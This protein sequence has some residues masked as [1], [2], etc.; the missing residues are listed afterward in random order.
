MA[1]QMVIDFLEKLN[2]SKETELES[3][4]IK[5]ESLM[6]QAQIDEILSKWSYVQWLR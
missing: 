3:P 6:F 5:N 1:G 4:Y 2:C